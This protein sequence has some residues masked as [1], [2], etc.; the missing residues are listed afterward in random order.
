MPRAKAGT[1]IKA[2]VNEALGQADRLARNPDFAAIFDRTRNSL[3]GDIECA[4]MDGSVEGDLA[5]LETVRKLQAL[6]AIKRSMVVSLASAESMA[7]QA[8]RRTQKG[9]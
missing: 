9:G 8:L 1:E 2:V 5:A 6:N 7:K 4:K 3:I